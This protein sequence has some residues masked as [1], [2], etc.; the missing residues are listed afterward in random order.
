MTWSNKP[1]SPSHTLVF[2]VRSSPNS[3]MMS[4]QYED[5]LAQRRIVLQGYE[6]HLGHLGDDEELF[7]GTYAS[8]GG[9]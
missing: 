9:P 1:L 3:R 4:A 6:P 8:F 7:R 5:R 2:K